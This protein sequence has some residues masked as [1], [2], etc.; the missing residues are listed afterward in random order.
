[1]E[2]SALFEQYSIS[3]DQK[4]RNELVQLH[5]YMVDILVKKYINRGVEYED[6]YQVGALALLSAVERFDPGKGIAFPAYATPT[7]LG[8]IKKYFRDKAFIMRLPRNYH[9]ISKKANDA[10][11]VLTSRLSR[12]PYVKEVA[13]YINC[14]EEEVLEAMEST[15]VYSMQSI[16]DPQQMQDGSLLYI[17][18]ILGQADEHFEK[19]EEREFI[20]S[21]IK[22]FSEE[23]YEFFRLRYMEN[24]SQ[25]QLAEH[26]NVSQMTISRIERKII[27]KFKSK[28]PGMGIVN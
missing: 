2:S 12:A 7:I 26:F 8:E 22:H 24:Q 4:I 19:A 1:M 15:K 5:L 20:K 21:V 17:E 18:D 9:Q 28:M 25:R 6:L 27:D 3:K 16:N 23:E 14:S 10:I 11:D 13:E